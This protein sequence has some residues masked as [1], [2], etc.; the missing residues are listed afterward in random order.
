MFSRNSLIN[1]IT[2]FTTGVAIGLTILSGTASAA[3]ATPPNPSGN[4]G[5]FKVDGIDFDD[6]TANEPRVT[7]SFEIDF[8]GFD[9]GARADIRFSAQAPTGRGQLLREDLD[10]LI[11]DDAADGG[12][13]DVDE[14]VRYDA[15]AWDLSAFTPSA[16]QGYHVKVDVDVADAPGGAKHKVLWIE[17]APVVPA[18]PAPLV[19]PVD[20][21]PPADEVLSEVVVL[22]VDVVAP[23]DTVPPVEVATPPVVVDSTVAAQP[24]VVVVDDAVAA[25]LVVPDSQGV[26]A[27]LGTTEVRSLVV[28]GRGLPASPDVALAPGNW[29]ISARVVGVRRAPSVLSFGVASVPA[30]AVD[31]QL[32]PGGTLP[33]TG[34]D[35]GLLTVVAGLLLVVGTVLTRQGRSS[36]PAGAGTRTGRSF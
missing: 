10:V 14:S 17:C 20:Q 2:T 34:V 32:T 33:R 4:N 29:G 16:Q 36:S 12:P 24:T 1:R 6:T 26:V 22:P 15:S 21:A 27:D 30:Q 19:A 11:S 25:S 3:P 31:A 13:G 35:T 7:C 8:F 18:P 28:A 23:A 9:L 5:V